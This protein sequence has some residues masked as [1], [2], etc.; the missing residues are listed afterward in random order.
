MY[1]ITTKLVNIHIASV[2][3]CTLVTIT[4]YELVELRCYKTLKHEHMYL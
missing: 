3:T 1:D 4:L 2:D